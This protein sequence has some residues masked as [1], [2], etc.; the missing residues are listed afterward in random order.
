MQER[1]ELENASKLAVVRTASRAGVEEGT[2][3]NPLLTC[4]FLQL[5]NFKQCWKRQQ[6]DKRTSMKDA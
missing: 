4:F 3:G 5:E 2:I 6:N 1:G